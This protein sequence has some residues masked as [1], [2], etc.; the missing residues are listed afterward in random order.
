MALIQKYYCCDRCGK[1]LEWG[2]FAFTDGEDHMFCCQN[3]AMSYYDIG[4]ID[5]DRYDKLE[6][7]GYCESNDYGVYYKKDGVITNGIFVIFGCKTDDVV[8]DKDKDITQLSSFGKYV[9][10]MNKMIANESRFDEIATRKRLDDLKHIDNRN[11]HI[12]Y[13]SCVFL[14]EICGHLFQ[15]RFIKYCS[16]QIGYGDDDV[17]PFVYHE[18]FSMISMWNGN[19][20]AF[21]M[22][23]D[24]DNFNG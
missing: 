24:T 14:V 17:I 1:S 2:E 22:N 19:K 16:K 4:S 8:Y 18:K 6:D 21:V 3:C 13:T 9:S 10:L 15:K 20:F 23:T 5:W 11:G 7:D 12:K